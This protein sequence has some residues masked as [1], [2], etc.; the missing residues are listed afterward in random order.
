MLH[1]E[2]FPVDESMGPIDGW[3]I[4][5]INSQGFSP[6][7]TAFGSEGSSIQNNYCQGCSRR[8]SD[9]SEIR[10]FWFDG[11][12]EEPP[13]I[14]NTQH[15]DYIRN[16]CEIYSKVLK[17]STEITDQTRTEEKV[18]I[19]EQGNGTWLDELV[20][21]GQTL[22]RFLGSIGDRK[23]N[24][25]EETELKNI[26][27]GL[28]KVSSCLN[29]VFKGLRKEIFF[30]WTQKIDSAQSDQD[31]PMLS[32]ETS[33][34][35]VQIGTDVTI[36]A[37]AELVR[38]FQWLRK[39]CQENKYRF[40]QLIE[41]EKD[42]F[43]YEE[44]KDRLVLKIRNFGR[45]DAG[46]YYVAVETENG[47]SVFRKTLRFENGKNDMNGSDLGTT[48]IE[49][50]NFSTDVSLGV[51]HANANAKPEKMEIKH[52]SGGKS[53]ECDVKAVQSVAGLKKAVAKALNSPKEFIEIVDNN[54]ILLYQD[55]THFEDFLK[56]EDKI[57]VIERPRTR[58]SQHERPV[59]IVEDDNES[60]GFPYGCTHSNS[61]AR[62]C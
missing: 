46:S 41:E 22:K 9:V 50:I 32:S 58:E 59:E 3:Y 49:E 21:I 7:V 55:D 39:T 36:E 26:Y 28:K 31:I 57:H 24:E 30:L 48:P 12:R 14:P 1:I 17:Q 27:S 35:N 60:T 61:K 42:K 33:D 62:Y 52:L 40:L 51:L 13:P 19:Q 11:K 20:E 43:E 6:N 45:Q 4:P 23:L 5:C 53:V 54:N 37:K 34:E 47:V 18:I 8:I 2:K 16:I 10:A 44:K 38:H 15:K 25:D 56:H 29:K